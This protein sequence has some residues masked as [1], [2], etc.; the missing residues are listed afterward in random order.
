MQVQQLYLNTLNKLKAS[1]IAT[2]LRDG[3]SQA[4]WRKR[5]NLLRR[6]ADYTS[7]PTHARQRF[8]TSRLRAVKYATLAADLAGLKWINARFLPHMAGTLDPLLDDLRRACRL[9]AVGQHSTKALPLTKGEYLRVKSNL[10]GR[11]RLMLTL[12]WRTASRVSDVTTLTGGSLTL[13]TGA[14]AEP[15]LLVVF[16]QT[17]ANRFAAH[18]SDHQVILLNPGE[19]TKLV[20]PHSEAHKKL[21]T[22]QDVSQLDAALKQTK[23]PKKIIEKWET[24]QPGQPLRNHYT[25]HSIKRGAA[26]RLWAQAANGRIRTDTVMRLL[27]HKQLETALGYCPAPQLAARALDLIIGEI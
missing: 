26:A 25:R 6:M 9:R 24:L 8:V 10:A 11:A 1:P 7:S 14:G 13:M 15:R 19:L 18:R 27:K 20:T 21:F 16:G 5:L 17:K 3:V 22:K 23:P 2:L 12:I 4:T